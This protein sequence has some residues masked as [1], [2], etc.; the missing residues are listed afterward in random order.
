M[1]SVT[2]TPPLRMI[3]RRVVGCNGLRGTATGYDQR[4]SPRGRTTARDG[5]LAARILLA[6]ARRP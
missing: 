3:G 2:D 6:V 5:A 1:Q 4:K